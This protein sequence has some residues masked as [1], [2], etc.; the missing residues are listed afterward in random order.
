[1]FR[2]AAPTFIG[3]FELQMFGC[4]A[5]VSVYYCEPTNIL[6]VLH[7]FFNLLLFSIKIP[8]GTAGNKSITEKIQEFRSGKQGDF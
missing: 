7:L 8:L 4:A 5:P 3:I 2:C 6:G 1:M